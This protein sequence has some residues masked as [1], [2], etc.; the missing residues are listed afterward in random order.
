[1]DIRV[2]I[3]ITVLDFE[4]DMIIY[5]LN[6]WPPLLPRILPQN[7]ANILSQQETK[8]RVLSCHSASDVL[9]HAFALTEA[10]LHHQYEVFL[11]SGFLVYYI[12][13]T[14]LLNFLSGSLITWLNKYHMFVTRFIYTFGWYRICW[15]NVAT[16][17]VC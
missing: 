14:M 7:I 3:T 1:M 9:R 17:Y 11:L 16:L 8:E 4:F 5:V 13:W 10:A 15:T 12:F 2:L 6:W